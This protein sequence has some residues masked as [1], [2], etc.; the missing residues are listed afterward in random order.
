M[1]ACFFNRVPTAASRAKNGRLSRTAGHTRSA[2]PAEQRR[3]GSAQ[4]RP[5]RV[6]LI[7]PLQFFWTEFYR[8]TD[9]QYALF[10]SN[11]VAA[12]EFA[13]ACRR[14]EKDDL[15]ILD[16]GPNRGTAI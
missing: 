5:A 14:R 9:E 13:D 8:I 6:R 7:H 10:S 16:P 15:L 2:F 11:H 12:V 1:R 3:P 4:L